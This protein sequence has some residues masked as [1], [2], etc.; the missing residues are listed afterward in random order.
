MKF[1]GRPSRAAR[2]IISLA[3]SISD[4]GGGRSRVPAR[5]S[6]GISS[7]S[8]SIDGTPITSS[9]RATSSGV[10]GMY[11]IVGPLLGFVSQETRVRGGAHE[12]R[13][14]GGIVGFKTEQPA[15]PVWILV[16]QFRLV[17]QRRVAGRHFAGQ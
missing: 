14:S 5:S 1:K 13:R 3:T 10:W 17:C 15:G 2:S 4:R 6:L 16:E 12:R 11:A 9:M 7:N 8:A